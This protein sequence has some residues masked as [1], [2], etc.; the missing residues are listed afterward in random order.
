MINIWY[1]YF[2]N[3]PEKIDET[4]YKELNY[5]LREYKLAY[6]ADGINIK[7]W[8]DRKKDEPK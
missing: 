3:P 4:S 6:K 8:A 7:I 1:K 2:N 5:I